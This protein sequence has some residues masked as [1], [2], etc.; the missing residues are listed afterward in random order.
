MAPTRKATASR[1][2]QRI[3]T[4]VTAK[5]SAKF[6]QPKQT[7]KALASLA[8]LPAQAA[9]ATSYVDPNF[10]EVAQLAGVPTP[11]LY[12]GFLASSLAFAAGTYVVLSKIKLI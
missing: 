7:V 4:A 3:V 5:P 9:F 8:L 10:V 2:Q 6:S 1:R 12:F 11:L